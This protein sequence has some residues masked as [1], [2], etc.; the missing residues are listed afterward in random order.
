MQV[1]EKLEG[2]NEK[3]SEKKAGK[4]NENIK[5]LQIEESEPKTEVIFNE[6][7]NILLIL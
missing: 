7:F 2:F 5:F 6:K 3:E 4:P 1:L